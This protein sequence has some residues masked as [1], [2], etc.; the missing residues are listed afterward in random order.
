[1]RFFREKIWNILGWRPLLRSWRPILQQ[2]LDLPLKRISATGPIWPE[3]LF[4]STAYNFGLHFIMREQSF[5]VDVL[6]RRVSLWKDF[7]SKWSDTKRNC[8]TLQV[9]YISV[10]MDNLVQLACLVICEQVSKLCCSEIK[11]LIHFSTRSTY[12][13]RCRHSSMIPWD[14]LDVLPARTTLKLSR[15]V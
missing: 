6:A 14:S 8:V 2:V 9:W 15:E 13:T 10:R 12:A 7:I 5:T 1:M 3:I 4:P 11:C